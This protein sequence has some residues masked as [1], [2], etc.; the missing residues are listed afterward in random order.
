MWCVGVE[1]WYMSVLHSILN[2]IKITPL[3]SS[4]Y[5]HTSGLAYSIKQSHSWQANR[6]SASQEIPR[7]LWN[8]KVH[9]CS[10]KC[11]P[12][13]P[14][15]SQLDPV[16]TLTSQDGQAV[17]ISQSADMRT[18]LKIQLLFEVK[19]F[20]SQVYKYEGRRKKNLASKC[21]QTS[22]S[23]MYLRHWWFGGNFLT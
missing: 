6:F 14:V 9:Y 18:H 1:M 10:H 5:M 19:L 16:H 20:L 2:L 15:L 21:N 17:N 3:F 4:W 23:E 12:L 22:E 7:I 13:V 11:P 8:P